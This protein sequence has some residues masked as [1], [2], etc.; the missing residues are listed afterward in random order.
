MG[1]AWRVGLVEAKYIYIYGQ[2]SIYMYMAIYILWLKVS[3]SDGEGV[4]ELAATDRPLRP[5]HTRRRHRPV[6]DPHRPPRH[7]QS[8][9]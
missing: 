2:R 5:R 1:A 8:V 3:T 4:G 7:A 9:I 6:R